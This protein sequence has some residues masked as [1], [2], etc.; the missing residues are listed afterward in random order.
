MKDTAGNRYILHFLPMEAGASLVGVTFIGSL[1]GNSSGQYL[2]ALES[3][4]GKPS[5]KS[6]RATG[7]G[8]DWCSKGDSPICEERPALRAQGSNEVNIF[9]V[10]GNRASREL[11]RRIEAKAAA[12]AAAKRRTPSF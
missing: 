3:K 9:L 2:A 12:V 11:D 10:S 4:F 1:E 7:F 8:A 5:S 6:A